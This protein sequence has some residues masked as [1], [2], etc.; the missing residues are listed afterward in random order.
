MDI[1]GALSLH[2]SAHEFEGTMQGTVGLDLRTAFPKSYDAVD[3]GYGSLSGSGDCGR[4]AL[5]R[6]AALRLASSSTRS[7]TPFC[8]SAT[9]NAVLGMIADLR[10]NKFAFN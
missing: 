8:T 7:T 10:V 5:S 3:D 9:R 6:Y 4:Q 1:G 2:K